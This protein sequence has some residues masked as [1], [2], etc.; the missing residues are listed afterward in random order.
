M[1]PGC[2]PGYNEQGDQRKRD[3]DA[4]ESPLTTSAAVDRVVH[5]SVILDL[6]AVSS[7]RAQQ[8]LQ[9]ERAS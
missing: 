7:Y 2:K 3:D 9:E 8:A 5:H 4:F 6:M 1:S